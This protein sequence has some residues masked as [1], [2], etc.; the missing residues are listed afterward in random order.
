MTPEQTFVAA[1]IGSVL[2]SGIVFYVFEWRARQRLANANAKTVE[3][4]ADS[5]TL[6]G[7]FDLISEMRKELDRLKNDLADLRCRYDIIDQKYTMLITYARKLLHGIS[8]LSTQIRRYGDEPEWSP[9]PP[10]EGVGDD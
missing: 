8:I 1:I 7:A 10:V 2:S 4:N 9:P 6:D 5:K 3:V